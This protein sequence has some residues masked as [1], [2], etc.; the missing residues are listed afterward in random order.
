METEGT[1]VFLI[2][3]DDGVLVHAP[4]HAVT[5]LVN[6]AAAQQLRRII[7]DGHLP[8][9]DDPVLM[10][11]AR[12][13]LAPPMPPPAKRTGP[14]APRRLNLF[15]TGDCQ[16][17]CRYCVPTAG[18]TPSVTI[19]RDRCA[20]ALAAFAGIVRR[21]QRPD[22][23]IYL[24]GGEPLR[25][26]ETVSFC[27]SEGRRQAQALDL[28]FHAAV[29][30]NGCFPRATAEWAA[31]RFDFL[32]VSLDGDAA[33]HDRQRPRRG[34]SGSFDTVAAF[35]DTLRREN[36]AFGI[37]CTVASGGTARIPEWTRFFCNAF[38]PRVI[39]FEP[40][41]PTARS[42]AAGLTPPDAERF[43]EGVIRAQ[44]VAR[45]YGVGVALPRCR[46]DRVTRCAQCDLVEDQMIVTPD[47]AVST[48]FAADHKGSPL[49]DPFVVG[50]CPPG[51]GGLD[52]DSRRI[53][54]VRAMG[55]ESMAHCRTCFCRWHCA[56]GCRVIHDPAAAAAIAKDA[57]TITRRLTLHKLM[58]RVGAA[59]TLL[60]TPLEERNRHASIC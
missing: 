21:D 37:R 5:A 42:D 11:L 22:L 28:P 33:V 44:N 17:D 60:T 18:D 15:I 54:R 25:C 58:Q 20:A 14:F 47:G 59:G 40:V 10:P 39:G 8:G 57:C 31:A 43:A 26:R 41:M 19:P 45:R 36:A 38:A 7:V 49:A 9:T 29:T 48:C 32:I 56:G 23:S 53:D 4:R 16:L 24:H 3:V 6:P 12:R 13:L 27:L 1:D 2:P 50:R 55:V 35:I 30:T 46:I 52:L 51:P 34:G